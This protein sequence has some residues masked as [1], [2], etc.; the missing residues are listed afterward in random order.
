M[1]I[2]LFHLLSKLPLPLLHALGS[3]LGW[4][5][6]LASPSYRSRLKDNIGRAGYPNHLNSAIRESGKNILELAFIWCA[7]PEKVMATAK[8]ENWE[9]AQEAL[10]SGRGVIFDTPPRLL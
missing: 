7:P 2:N 8:V 1:L 5:V 3:L 10:D 6:Y 9:A 4:T